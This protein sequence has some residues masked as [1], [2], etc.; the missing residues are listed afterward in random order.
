MV[1]LSM[2]RRRVASR[3]PVWL[4]LLP[5][6]LAATA[7]RAHAQ[8]EISRLVAS[9]G[10]LNDNLGTAVDIS[11]D[12]GMVAAVGHD[13]QGSASGAVYVADRAPS[14]W[15]FVQKL[16]ASDG[17]AGTQ[18]G[19]DIQI[20][21]SRAL[22]GAS[23]AVYFFE[24][25]AGSWVEVQKITAS[26][27][28]SG[29]GFGRHLALDADRALIAAPTRDVAGVETV[30]E[31]YVFEIGAGGWVEV[32]R[33]S[34]PTGRSGDEFGSVALLG[35]LA[36]VGAPGEDVH[37][38]SAKGAAYVF[39]RDAAGWGPATQINIF[40]GNEFDSL[41]R[42]VGIS[43]NRLF[44]GAP[45]EGPFL[46]GPV[47]VFRRVGLDWVREARVVSEMPAGG[48]AREGFDVSGETLVVGAQ[49]AEQA[50]AFKR[51]SRNEWIQDSSFAV[52]PVLDFSFSG[53]GASIAVDG[54]HV[55]L[56]GVNNGDICDSF[57]S[58]GS[59][60]VF[61]LPAAS[62]ENFCDVSD[63]STG[64][65]AI[66]SLAGCTQVARN[67]IGL[68]ARPVP[69][70][71]PG[72]F[73]YGDTAI[74]SIPFG[75]GS[76]CVAGQTFRLSVLLSRGG[77]LSVDV[78]LTNPPQVGGLITPGSTW[79][80]QALYRDPDAGGAGFNLSDALQVS[81]SN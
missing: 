13:A 53:F 66:L 51:T 81:F 25:I 70:G 3:L 31:V 4:V 68:L 26:D 15:S 22:I 78:D 2:C 65:P 46:Q 77:E 67:E 47:Y 63:N 59:A 10:A 9:D 14:G 27:G 11:G 30:G 50:F 72:L 49:F 21:G 62:A 37:G 44:I 39:E 38:F 58:S 36:L 35:D 7:S 17:T 73:F 6:A 79:F 5:I 56:G 23:E 40:E 69:D 76:R 29:D 48:F 75:D 52:E 33:L 60:Y 41:G 45:G 43:R 28:V 34:S 24:R 19:R 32:D 55:L 1:S 20:E 8:C 57:C 18:F 61:D 80:F 54:D 64:E 42:S 74:A 12:V 71:R 16:T